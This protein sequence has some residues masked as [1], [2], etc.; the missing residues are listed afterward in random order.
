M[1]ALR[2]EL[3]ERAPKLLR[4]TIVTCDL[5]NDSAEAGASLPLASPRFAELRAEYRGL[6]RRE[7]PP[8]C[9]V[10]DVLETLTS[11]FAS[12]TA[13]IPELGLGDA[14]C[15]CSSRTLTALSVSY[16]WS[17]PFIRVLKSA[18]LQQ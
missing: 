13:G 5:V 9:V 2:Q 16:R 4:R 1:R 11:C 17:Q 7:Q 3:A 8:S 6:L 12:S 14:V 18:A 10:Q 15:P